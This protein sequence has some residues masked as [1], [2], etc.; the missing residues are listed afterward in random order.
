MNNFFE[1]LWFDLVW[2]HEILL[3]IWPLHTK[4][5]NISYVFCI[6]WRIS[7]I[8]NSCKAGLSNVSLRRWSN[9]DEA[10]VS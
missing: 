5:L 1:N 10:H 8:E 3:Q 9:G 6:G 4:I 7:R 2:H